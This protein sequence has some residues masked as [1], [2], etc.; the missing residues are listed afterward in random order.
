MALPSIGM[1]PGDWSWYRRD[2][3]RRSPLQSSVR[4][5]RIEICPEI[6]QLVL[7]VRRR[8]EQRAIQIL[9][10]NRDENYP[11]GQFSALYTAST[12]FWF[13]NVPRSSI[14]LMSIR[15]ILIHGA[16]EWLVFIE[17]IP[18]SGGRLGGWNHDGRTPRGIVKLKLTAVFD[19]QHGG[20][21]TGWS[22]ASW[23]LIDELFVNLTMPAPM[24]RA[25]AFHSSPWPASCPA[26]ACAISCSTVSRSCSSL[27]S[28]AWVRLI[29]ITWCRKRQA[30]RRFLASPNVSVQPVSPCSSINSLAIPATPFS[31]SALPD[32]LAPAARCPAPPKGRRHVPNNMGQ[33]PISIQ[34]FFPYAPRS[35]DG[36]DIPLLSRPRHECVCR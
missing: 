26:I 25:V 15:L 27:P 3:I 7:Q 33:C 24:R 22:P 31:L 8:P 16:R 14:R 21:T 9:A 28:R 12:P 1:E 5:I 17:Q 13:G 4:A 19:A 10:S 20:F 11:L 32:P 29:Q 34:V 18:R 30:P 35:C 23:G 2:W 6:E 36:M